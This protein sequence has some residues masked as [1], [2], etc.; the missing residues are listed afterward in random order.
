MGISADAIQKD[1]FG[2]IKQ[3][4]NDEQAISNAE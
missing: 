4:S 1:S 3:I 2:L